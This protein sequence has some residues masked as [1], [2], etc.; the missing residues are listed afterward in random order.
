MFIANSLHHGKRAE[1]LACFKPCTF[2]TVTMDQ[3]KRMGEPGHP[4]P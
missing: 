3:T 4:A 1:P 2:P